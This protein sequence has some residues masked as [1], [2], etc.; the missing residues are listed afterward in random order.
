MTMVRNNSSGVRHGCIARISSQAWA[1]CLPRIS[2][3]ISGDLWGILTIH[4]CLSVTKICQAWRLLS[5][6]EVTKLH[7]IIWVKSLLGVKLWYEVNGQDGRC[8]PPWCSQ[9]GACKVCGFHSAWLGNCKL[10]FTCMAEIHGRELTGMTGWGWMQQ[11]RDVNAYD[12]KFAVHTIL[13]PEGPPRD[14]TTAVS[15]PPS[16]STPSL[17]TGPV[18]TCITFPRSGTLTCQINFS[19]D[20]MICSC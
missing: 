13:E 9:R 6:M 1:G 8:C 3:M 16:S 14:S 7:T 10:M 19:T 17:W 20:W 5:L 15:W 4:L 18:K 2:G 12:L 11:G